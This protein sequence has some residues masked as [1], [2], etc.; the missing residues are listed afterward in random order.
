MFALAWLSDEIDGLH[1]SLFEAEGCS[2]ARQRRGR[3]ADLLMASVSEP[4]QKRPRI[5]DQGETHEQI[6]DGKHGERAAH[7][8]PP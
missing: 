6:A 3:V 1:G 2:T 4:L 8:P 5:F 7:W